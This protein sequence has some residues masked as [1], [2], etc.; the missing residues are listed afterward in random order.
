M[1]RKYL[2][3]FEWIVDF[4]GYLADSEG[5][6]VYYNFEE[7]YEFRDKIENVYNIVMKLQFP[8]I[9]EKEKIKRMFSDLNIKL[10]AYFQKND[11]MYAHLIAAIRC[12][13]V[14]ELYSDHPDTFDDRLR[15]D[16]FIEEKDGKEEENIV[17]FDK[18]SEE[19]Q[20]HIDKAVNA[21]KKKRS[22]KYMEKIARIR[23]FYEYMQ[24]LNDKKR[25]DLIQELDSFLCCITE[26]DIDDYVR[27]VGERNMAM[28]FYRKFFVH[29]FDNRKEEKFVLKSE[30]DI[31]LSN[32]MEDVLE[33]GLIDWSEVDHYF[34]NVY[35]KHI[36]VIAE[37][38]GVFDH[39]FEIKKKD[40]LD[41]Y[42][43]YI[44]NSNYFMRSRS[45][46]LDSRSRTWTNFLEN[47]EKKHLIKKDHHK[48]T[49]INPFFINKK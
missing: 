49:I 13:Y 1:K 34:Y 27:D 21:W 2:C 26:E 44:T 42:N 3:F 48:L 9:N 14:Q 19:D 5:V 38:N 23:M 6:A 20:K 33:E 24:E 17:H 45:K 4:N 8:F 30:K 39:I 32:S 47:C 40:F 25:N 12:L 15:S 18:L 29:Y 46:K 36:M 41:F 16:F 37:R 10:P 31:I 22:R 7:I 35:W 43:S 28:F 11:Y